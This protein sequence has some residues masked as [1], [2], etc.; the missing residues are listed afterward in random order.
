MKRRILVLEDSNLAGFRWRYSF[1]LSRARDGSFSLTFRQSVRGEGR[2]DVL[3]AHELRSGLDVYRA[4]AEMLGVVGYDVNEADAE[5]ITEELVQFDS[6]LAS[7]FREAPQL[8]ETEEEIDQSARKE[9][10]R[11]LVEPFAKTIEE[12]VARVPDIPLRRPGWI[13]AFPSSRTW[14]RHFIEQYVVEHGRLPTGRHLIQVPGY[15][16]PTHDFPDWER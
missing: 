8:I 14:L 15:H 16:G 2:L 3:P 9:V 4:L 7:Q 6:E 13:G 1:W 5:T 12:Y 10:H 11:K